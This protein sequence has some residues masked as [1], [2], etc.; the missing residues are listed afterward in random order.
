MGLFANFETLELARMFSRSK[1][2]LEGKDLERAFA[3]LR[4]NDLIWAYWVN[5]Y[6]MGNEPPA[7]DILY[8]NADTTNLP[9]ALHADLLGLI[10][11]GG[12]TAGSGPTIGGHA[13]KLAA[14][15]LRHL[16]DG[17]R[18]RPHHALGRLLPDPR[19]A[20]RRVDLRAQPVRPHPVADQPAGQPEGAL[21]DQRRRARDAGGVPRRRRHPHRQLVAALARLARRPRRRAGR[22]ADGLG[23]ARA[24]AARRRARRLRAA[25]P[26]EHRERGGEPGRDPDPADRRTGDPRGAARPRGRRAHPPRLQRDR[27]ERRDGGALRGALPRHP[28][29]HLR[30]AR[31]RRLARRRRCP[32][33]SPGWRGCRRAC[34]TRSGSA[35]STSSA[36]PGAA[37]S[38]SSS[39]TTFPG[40]RAR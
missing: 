30:R 4:P 5:N 13:L 8:W 34:S 9:A 20:R 19:R 28:G 37:R 15:H 27:R 17:R 2:V 22:R 40:G 32:T 11:T 21:P 33:A 38:P 7:F 3:W 14:H 26:R 39:C 18:D 1:G 35:R 25:R 31:R 10:E 36:S 24:P 6:L 29:R 16:P 23:L 12:V